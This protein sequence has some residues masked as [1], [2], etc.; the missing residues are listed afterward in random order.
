LLR[1]AFAARIISEAG[2]S[3]QE[4]IEYAFRLATSR[5]PSAE[6]LKVLTTLLV[7]LQKDYQADKPAAT[8]L[9]NVGAFRHDPIHDTSVLA[10]WTMFASTLLN[11]DEVI[12]KV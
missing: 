9:L 10:A 11:M 3:N 1:H 2:E 4:R 5:I 7:G 8:A 12:S 6:E